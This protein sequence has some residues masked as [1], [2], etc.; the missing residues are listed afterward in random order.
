ML[1]SIVTYAMPLYTRIYSMPV[2]CAPDPRPR[3]ARSSSAPGDVAG[4]HAKN[5]GSGET[6]L[7]AYA[8]LSLF[9]SSM[10]VCALVLA[11]PAPSRRA[12]D[13]TS[14]HA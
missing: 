3:S 4:A 6:R 10:A 2:F 8:L 14:R 12:N 9:S 13:T 7:W 5:K 11:L 1:S